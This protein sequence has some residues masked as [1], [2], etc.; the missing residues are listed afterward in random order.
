MR[1]ESQKRN[2]EEYDY[3]KK[4]YLE[5]RKDIVKNIRDNRVSYVDVDMYNRANNKNK[6]ATSLLTVMQMEKNEANNLQT[7][8]ERLREAEISIRRKLD[9]QARLLEENTENLRKNS[10]SLEEYIHIS[11]KSRRKSDI[12]FN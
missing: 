5:Q 12:S 10:S 8:I 9:E 7:S 1:K 6:V 3:L 4:Q 2:E 11:P